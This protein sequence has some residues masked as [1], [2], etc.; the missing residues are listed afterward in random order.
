MQTASWLVFLSCVY[1]FWRA[2]RAN[3]QTSLLHAAY[4]AISAWLAWTVLA[5]CP[6]YSSQRTAVVGSYIALCLTGCAGVAVLGARR[7]GVL[8]WNFVVVGL[9]AVN[10][11]PFAEG[12]VLGTGFNLDWLRALCVAATVFVGVLNYLPT[13]LAPAAVL[14]LVG[15]CLVALG[16]HSPSSSVETTSRYLRTGWL[17]LA[18]VPWLAFAALAGTPPAASEFDAIWI[19]YRN[20]FGFLWGQRLREQFNRSAANLGWPVILRWQGLRLV[21]GSTA[22]D[23]AAQATMVN[24]LHALMKRFGPEANL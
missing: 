8:A 21:S 22:P 11:L 19:D 15:S 13:R 1:P 9:L 16:L 20:R 12:L 23:A 6:E 17:A 4:W 7:P 3:R 5:F 2:W 24:T 10:L 14:L 18:F